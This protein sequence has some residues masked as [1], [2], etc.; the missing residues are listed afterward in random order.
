M[1]RQLHN[2]NRILEPPRIEDNDIASLR[3]SVSLHERHDPAV[4]LWS[5][6]APRDEDRLLDLRVIACV[7]PTSLARSVAVLCQAVEAVKDVLGA[8]GLFGN[9]DIQP[10]EVVRGG[11]EAFVDAREFGRD[12]LQLA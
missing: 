5:I 6:S 4:A 8:V 11:H 7:E 2:S 12:Y 9:E 3:S 1:E 10:D